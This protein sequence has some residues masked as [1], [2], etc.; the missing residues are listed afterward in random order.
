MGG[1]HESPTSV[2]ITHI[3]GG[4]SGGGYR[5]FPGGGDSICVLVKSRVIFLAPLRE[6][7]TGARARIFF[8]FLKINF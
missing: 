8:F 5:I 2:D 3:I 7:A 4:Y 6:N 1:G